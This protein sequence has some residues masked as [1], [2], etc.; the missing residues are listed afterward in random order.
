MPSYCVEPL[1]S[2]HPSTDSFG[3]GNSTSSETRQGDR[4]TNCPELARSTVVPRATEN[5]GELSSK[6]TTSP[7]DH[8]PSVCSGGSTPA[9][10]DASIGGLTNFWACLETAGVPE[11]VCQIH[12]ASRPAGIHMQ[13]RYEGP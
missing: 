8:L 9:V 3:P 4:S 11:D 12:M 6:V 10:T 2:L 5:A 13:Q 1:D 7:I